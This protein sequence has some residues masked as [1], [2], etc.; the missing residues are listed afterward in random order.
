MK[1]GSSIHFANYFKQLAYLIVLLGFSVCHAGSY[2]DFFSALTQDD[3]ERVSALLSRGFD[4]NAVD[5][6]GTP[7]LILAI[8]TTSFNV[9][10]ALVQWPTT[11]V[12]SR[13]SADES[14][15]M[16][17]ALKGELALC[18]AII[19]RG[20]DVNKPGWA[21][22]HYAATSENVDVVRLL[23]DEN[24]YIDAASPNGTTPL[25]MAAHYGTDATVKLLIEAGADPLLKNDLGLTA[26][27]FAHRANR[28]T[29]A[30][31]IAG[32]VRA[33]QPK[34]AW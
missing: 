28:A 5:P 10:T 3:P 25:M 29:P 12:E 17:A 32:A 20:G 26:L 15:L 13:N 18:Q 2:D 19:K 31:M 6:S 24:A 33:L 21:P 8:K 30:E 16:L 1:T 7:A 22:L 9:A 27:D 23:L 14:P 4:P 34:G 11:K